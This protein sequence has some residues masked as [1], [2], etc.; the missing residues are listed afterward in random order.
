MAGFIFVMVS[1][2]VI[3][4]AL[5]FFVSICESHKVFFIAHPELTDRTRMAHFFENSETY[6]LL[7]SEYKSICE[8]WPNF[9]G[10]ELGILFT[11]FCAL[12][13]LVS[14]AE[15]LSG[16]SFLMWVSVIV[17][18]IV[19]LGM[20]HYSLVTLRKYREF[21]KSGVGQMT[22]PRI[23]NTILSESNRYT[24]IEHTADVERIMDNIDLVISL[25]RTRITAAKRL[26]FKEHDYAVHWLVFAL[27]FQTFA[28]LIFAQ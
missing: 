6:R 19:M 28:L 16:T 25:M 23:F 2:C 20:I 10:E 11:C 24:Y 3:A 4:I 27:L 22:F 18:V 21:K 14:N 9:K 15:R 12:A 17:P 1:N 7:V 8:E 5:A 13:V 26:R